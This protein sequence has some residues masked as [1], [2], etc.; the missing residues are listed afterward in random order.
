MFLNFS[1]AI[2]YCYIF[3]KIKEIASL[4]DVFADVV[5]IHFLGIE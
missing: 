5:N 3:L 2:I 1:K 4:A